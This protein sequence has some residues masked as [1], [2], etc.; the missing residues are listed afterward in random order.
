MNIVLGI[1]NPG[2]EYRGT[3]H[4]IGF[5]V[6]DALAKKHRASFRKWTPLALRAVAETPEGSACL[7]KPQTYVNRSGKVIPAIISEYGPLS[8]NFLAVCDDINLSLGVLR[9]RT[10]GS[11]GGHNGL[12]SLIESLGTEKFPRM[13]IG[14]GAPEG[15]DTADYVL[16]HFQRSDQ[17]LVDEAVERAVAAVELWRRRGAAAAM[18]EFN[19]KSQKS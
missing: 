6:V 1:G 10:D 2:S 11:S 4:N 3:R 13:R 15:V 17:P 18:N 12:K 8:E 7:I 9:I 19:Q 14:V 5:A 16:D